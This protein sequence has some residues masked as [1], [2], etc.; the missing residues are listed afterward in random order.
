MSSWV[1]HQR[2]FRHRSTWVDLYWGK[3]LAPF[4]P[5][6]FIFL[7]PAPLHFSTPAPFSLATISSLIENIYCRVPAAR[8]G[9]QRTARGS[10]K[11][12]GQGSFGPSTGGPDLQGNHLDK[13][14]KR[15][16]RTLDSPYFYQDR[17]SLARHNKYGGYSGY[18]FIAHHTNVS[19]IGNFKKNGP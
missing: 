19:F 4:W 11:T 1:R 17:V 14:F 2:G 10:D 3:I 15:T 7:L 5:A 6:P 16:N 13:N 8:R 9:L 12:R 18:L